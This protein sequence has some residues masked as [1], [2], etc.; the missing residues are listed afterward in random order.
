MKEREREKGGWI[1]RYKTDFDIDF[2]KKWWKENE[3]MS[4]ESTKMEKVLYYRERTCLSW[5]KVERGRWEKYDHGFRA[6]RL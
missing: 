6:Q 2:M 5:K 4:P 3:T 1:D